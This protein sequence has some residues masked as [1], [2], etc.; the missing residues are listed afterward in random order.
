MPN[1]PDLIKEYVVSYLDDRGLDTIEDI[2][3]EITDVE[4]SQADMTNY[5]DSRL[6]Q[7]PDYVKNN[8]TPYPDLDEAMRLIREYDKRLDMLEKLR[9]KK[10]KE[11]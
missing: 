6:R 1:T 2:L 5:L 10:M 3:E 4:Q 9:H 7:L 8:L 11:Y